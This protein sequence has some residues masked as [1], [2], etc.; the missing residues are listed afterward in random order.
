MLLAKAGEGLVVY[1]DVLMVT[2]LFINYFLC[3][4]NI[5]T[6]IADSCVCPYES[7]CVCTYGSCRV[8]FTQQKNVF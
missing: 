8:S 2:N 5:L 6:E 3:L 7:E 1:A 4:V